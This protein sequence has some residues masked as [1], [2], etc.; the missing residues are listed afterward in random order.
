MYIYKAYIYIYIYIYIIYIFYSALRDFQ[1]Q[2]M[3]LAMDGPCGC[4][5]RS[6][7]DMLDCIGGG[8]QLSDDFR[9]RPILYLETRKQNFWKLSRPQN[10][11]FL[12]GEY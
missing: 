2:K 9:G 7:Q 6:V 8:S 4:R 11:R 5:A 10:I 3:L 12:G 1:K